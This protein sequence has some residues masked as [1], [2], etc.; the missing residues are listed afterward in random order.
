MI[1]VIASLATALTKEFGPAEAVGGGYDVVHCEERIGGVRRLALENVEPSSGDPFFP[2]RGDQRLL[3]DD[4]SA[5]DI[6]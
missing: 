3:V 5:G 1:P 6:D 2:K 4:R